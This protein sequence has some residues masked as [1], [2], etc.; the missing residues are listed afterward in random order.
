MV[1]HGAH[2]APNDLGILVIQTVRHLFRSPIAPLHLVIAHLYVL[3]V[4]VRLLLATHLDFTH[5]I[6]EQPP[7]VPVH[8]IFFVHYQ[9]GFLNVFLDCFLVPLHMT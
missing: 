8:H 1:G 3:V 4:Q 7:L 5:V 9:S 2:N 6:L